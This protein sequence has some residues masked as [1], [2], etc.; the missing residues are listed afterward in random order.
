MANAWIEHVRK[1]ARENNKTYGCAL[2][3]PAAKASYKKSPKKPTQ[4]SER[5]SMG[6]NDRPAKDSA[7]SAPV[8][9]LRERM[10]VAGNRAEASA[11][12][13]NRVAD[14]RGKLEPMNPEVRTF[15]KKMSG[16]EMRKKLEEKGRMYRG[17][18]IKEGQIVIV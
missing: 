6:A 10:R 9:T 14:A 5:G 1:F 17:G 8:K 11:Y 2:S 16:A 12:L 4:K 13:S 15:K 3:D 18:K 7:A